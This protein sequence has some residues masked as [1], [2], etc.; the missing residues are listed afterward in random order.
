MVMYFCVLIFNNSNK[1]KRLISC[2]LNYMLLLPASVL[3]PYYLL[4]SG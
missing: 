3:P 2:F 4:L 1:N